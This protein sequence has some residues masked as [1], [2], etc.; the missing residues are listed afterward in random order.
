[1]ANDIDPGEFEEI[2]TKIGSCQVRL[3]VH[4]H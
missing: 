4:S 1:V 2:F 3:K